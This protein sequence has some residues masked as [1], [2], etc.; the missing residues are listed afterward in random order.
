MKSSPERIEERIMEDP[1]LF[2]NPAIKDIKGKIS[3]GSF[4]RKW[5]Q[6]APNSNI[7]WAIK[8][9]TDKMLDT[10]YDNS[11]KAIKDSKSELTFKQQDYRKWN[12]SKFLKTNKTQKKTIRVI[13]VKRKGKT[14]KRTITPRWETKTLFAL[15]KTAN[16]KPGSKQYKEYIANIVKSTGRSRQAVVKKVQRTRQK[17]NKGGKK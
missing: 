15:K 16:L 7:S 9:I 4:K 10:I 1:L 5:K 17:L 13:K 8:H 11:G 2:A 3:R 14:Y 12:K 6:K